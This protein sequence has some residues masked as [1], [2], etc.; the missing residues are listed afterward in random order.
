[1][2]PHPT[3]DSP[4]TIAQWNTA[5]GSLANEQENTYPQEHSSIQSTI[6]EDQRSLRFSDNSCYSCMLGQSCGKV[7][8]AHLVSGPY[9]TPSH[10]CVSFGSLI[11]IKEHDGIVL[12]RNL[13][14]D[15][16]VAGD[17]GTVVHIHTDAVAYEVEFLE[18]V[19][20]LTH[21]FL[22]ARF[23]CMFGAPPCWLTPDRVSG[24]NS[25]SDADW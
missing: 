25:L 9:G 10:Q 13:P 21:C 7:N 5:G 19:W 20:R 16:L 4:G 23:H 24:C 18:G 15:G 6:R 22:P 12:T 1:M 8:S 11:L 17:A 2:I 3:F 14:S